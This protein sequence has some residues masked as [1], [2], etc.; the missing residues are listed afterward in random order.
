MVYDTTKTT[1][2]FG[3]KFGY[4]NNFNKYIG[5]RYT[6]SIDYNTSHKM[7]QNTFG[8]KL[9]GYSA[10]FL[11]WASNVDLLINV[12]NNEKMTLTILGG[13]GFGNGV[14]FFS[15]KFDD[16]LLN[17]KSLYNPTKFQLYYI[18]INLGLTLLIAQHHQVELLTRFTSFQM[19][20]YWNTSTPG[21]AY[22]RPTIISLGYLYV[23]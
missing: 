7:E 9:D 6:L 20:E 23:F 3:A 18:P 14:H 4:F 10:S 19:G 15:E 16:D 8:A 22:Y 11:T 1:F 21:Y 5:L 17:Y 12:Y 2:N 13:L